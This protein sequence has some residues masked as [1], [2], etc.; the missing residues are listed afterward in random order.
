[1]VMVPAT[2]FRWSHTRH[3]SDTIIIGRD[4]EFTAQR[5]PNWVQFL[6][7][8]LKL[9]AIIQFFP[10]L[11]RTS[12]G[13]LTKEEE[14]FIPQSERNKLFWEARVWLL[15]FAGIA[16]LSIYME[17]ILPIMFFVLP[18][19]YAQPFTYYLNITQHGGL[20]EDVL[21]H[22]LNT[23]TFYTNPIYRFLYSNM[24][25][26]IEHHMF[27]MVPYYNLAALH[28]EI[29]RDCPPAYPSS[30]AAFKEALSAIYRQRKD[31]GYLPVRPLPD[32]AKPYRF[33]P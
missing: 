11:I 30:W 26:H 21:D 20:S 1:M 23:R 10:G 27:P 8:F 28:E 15:L 2:M 31:P 13:R 9:G 19:F 24:N 25:Y 32:T 29:K 6:S 33:Q 7:N 17:S 12:M 14:V 22:R 4:R 16:V 5:P 18:T 3:H